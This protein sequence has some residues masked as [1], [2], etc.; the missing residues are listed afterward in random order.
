MTLWSLPHGVHSLLILTEV[1]MAVCSLVMIVWSLMIDA[2]GLLAGYEVDRLGNPDWDCLF[3][4][5]VQV[6]T[7]RGKE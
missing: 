7:L 6:F 5:I 1:M 2:W 4:L 3:C